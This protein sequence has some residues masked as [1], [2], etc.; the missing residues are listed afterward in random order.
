MFVCLH[1]FLMA[2]AQCPIGSTVNTPGTYNANDV[3][4]V[5]GSVS[6]KITLKNKAT[7]YVVS[8]GNFT[9]II[10]ANKG[11]V[12]NVTTGGTFK[13]SQANSFAATLTN[14]GT[15]E[16]GNGGLTLENGA[17]I[18]NESVFTWVASWNMNSAVTVSN[19][20]CGTMT[21]KN[22]I[23]SLA[24]NSQL[25]NNGLM[26]FQSGLSTSSGT[27]LTNRGK[28]YLNGSL[29]PSGAITNQSLMVSNGSV[30]LNGGDSLV[31]TDKLFFKSGLT[32]G[33]KIRNDGLLWVA[34]SMQ[35]NSAG[36]KQNLSTAELRIDGALANNVTIQGAGY[37]YIAGAIANNGTVAGLSS[38]NKLTVNQTISTGTRTNLTVNAGMPIYDTT[39]Y[40]GA[41]ASPDAC[42]LRLL[43]ASLSE[44]NAEQESGDAELTWSTASEYNSSSFQIERSND[45]MHFAKI[46]SV[47]AHGIS[48]SKTNYSFEDN[49]PLNG[50]AYYRLK[51]IDIDNAFQYSNVVVLHTIEKNFISGKIAPNPFV[52]QFEISISLNNADQVHIRI[53]DHSGRIVH[54][55]EQHASKG[56]THIVVNSLSGLSAGIYFVEIS[57]TTERLVQKIVKQ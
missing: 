23:Y 30:T 57:T 18:S 53:M 2:D 31:N 51:M 5:S 52:S 40:L 47:N 56:N 1:V 14:Q 54:M 28:L 38:S 20:A 46:G 39:N 50:T 48:H 15:T 42:A 29:D 21:F 4:C 34:S 22:N 13:P 43:P 9:G 32:G 41:N 36:I 37:L 11:S 25:L 45:G 35:L 12:I 26:I 6:G 19:T 27:S 16:F 3:A 33:K 17:S 49:S 10:D 44:L 7:L 8:G 24:N 55:E